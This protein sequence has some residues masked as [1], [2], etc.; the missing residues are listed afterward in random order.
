MPE[1]NPHLFTWES[2]DMPELQC[3]VLF[4]EHLPYQEFVAQLDSRR[5]RGRN[6]YPIQALFWTMIAGV[7]FGHD[8]VNSLLRELARNVRWHSFAA[9][10]HSTAEPA[11]TN[12]AIR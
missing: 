3:L 7:A 5:D 6:D 9:S 1:N 12:A 8:S 2:D 4:L 10:T 11:E